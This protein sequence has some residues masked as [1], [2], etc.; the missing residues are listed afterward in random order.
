VSR[1]AWLTVVV[2]LAVVVAGVGAVLYA[3]RARAGQ[4]AA[5]MAPLPTVPVTR[6]DLV[7]SVQQPGLL[8]YAGTYQL[9]GHRAGT[10]TAVPRTGQVIDRGQPVYAVD[11]RPVPLL[12]GD[13][14]LYRPLATGATGTDVRQLEQ[15]LVEL[16]HAAGLTVDDRYTAATATAVRRW[17]GVLGLPRT[18]AV[19]AGDAVLAPGPVRI[20]EVQVVAGTT[21]G[22][23]QVIAAAT[24]TG[25]GVRV[26][27]DRR[28][29]ALAAVDRLV[30]IQLFGG[31]AVD[32]VVTFVGSAATAPQEPQGSQTIPV[33]IRVT[34][35]ESDLGGVFEGPVTV[36]FPGET[37]RGVLSVPIEA[38]TLGTG[39]GYAVVVVDAAG[40]HP[41][42]VSTGL[43]T[44]TRV[45]IV[46]PGIVEGTRVEVPTL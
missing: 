6:G 3:T 7:N 19:D 42:D 35:P 31:R 33:E 15:N 17:Q 34:S 43:I 27:L 44:S 36:V 10:V 14:P 18:G 12:F 25:H 40:R 8:G 39:D 4:P 22:P 1:R 38:L 29:R 16:G 21:S 30:R 23:G 5:G 28:Y 26:A 41:V 13:L 20:T 11:Q 46:G 32:G 9:I 45:E 2:V 24:G 37:R